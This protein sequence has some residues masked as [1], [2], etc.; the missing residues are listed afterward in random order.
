MMSGASKR[1]SAVLL[2]KKRERDCHPTA[3]APSYRFDSLIAK[4]A[5]NGR[6]QGRPL[7]IRRI[8]GNREID[9]YRDGSMY[10]KDNLVGVTK[11]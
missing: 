6:I 4:Q 7:I 1:S 3:R 5:M 9:I 11:R 8:R 10:E 2:K